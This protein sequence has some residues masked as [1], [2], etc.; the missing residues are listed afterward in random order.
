M[1]IVLLFAL[2]Q[3]EWCLQS[4]SCR[5]LPPKSIVPRLLILLSIAIQ[6]ASC[7]CL[8]P[9]SS[10]GSSGALCID[11][12]SHFVYDPN[13]VNHKLTSADIV[14]PS[15]PPPSTSKHNTSTSGQV[16]PTD[17]P[18]PDTYFYTTNDQSD[19]DEH[20]SSK[21]ETRSDKYYVPER[22][23]YPPRPSPRKR[24]TKPRYY[25]HPANSKQIDLIKNSPK[26]SIFIP[27]AAY[28]VTKHRPTKKTTK[29]VSVNSNASQQ[30]GSRYYSSH[31]KERSKMAADSSNVSIRQQ[32]RPTPTVNFDDEP[33]EDEESNDE[34]EDGEDE[35]YETKKESAVYGYIRKPEV[36]E[37]RGQYYYGNQR[38][39]VSG[40]N[41]VG[42]VAMPSDK[43]DTKVDYGEEDGYEEVPSQSMHEKHAVEYLPIGYEHHHDISTSAFILA[44]LKK[45]IIHSEK[46]H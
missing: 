46:R 7:I 17:H 38:P 28:S 24:K 42:E 1:W 8:S 35:E 44:K 22:K 23:Y 19:E 11:S 43:F 40:S 13:I 34:S 37:F 39:R 26:D 6:L 18:G 32:S 3:L 15:T 33:E 30:Y 12:D 36:V 16:W 10:S 45:S 41:A 29:I 25:I 2:F 5:V 9:S 14:D 20:H 21:P 27:V 4:I 31:S